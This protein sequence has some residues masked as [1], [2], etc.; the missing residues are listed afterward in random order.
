MVYFSAVGV[1]PSGGSSPYQPPEG[2]TPTPA[3]QKQLAERDRHE[4]ES[5]KL[6]KEGKLPEAVAAAEAMLAI[7]R[8][9]L[10]EAH[11]HYA[12]GL[13][14]LADVHA[15]LGDFPEAEK[16]Y[17]QSLAIRK[18][19][20]GE[21]D[22][23]TLDTMKALARLYETLGRLN[24]A[25]G[26]GAAERKAYQQ[27]ADLRAKLKEWKV[28]WQTPPGQRAME[29][30][31]A[32]REAAHK[33]RLAHLDADQRKRLEKV[34][35]EQVDP[36]EEY[37]QKADYARGE[38]LLRAAVKV[39]EEL[40]GKDD[41]ESIVLRNNLG[42]VCQ[43]TGDYL[44]AAQ[45]FRDNLRLKEQVGGEM[46]PMYGN[47]LHNLGDLFSDMGNLREA[48][49]LLHRALRID[50]ETI[51][52]RNPFYTQHLANLAKLYSRKKD[53]KRA[54]RFSL[55]VIGIIREVDGDKTPFDC[56]QLNNLALTYLSQGEFGRAEQLMLESQE[57]ARQAG[58][59][60]WPTPGIS[61][62]NRGMLYLARGDNAQAEQ[63]LTQALQVRR[64]HFE[65]TYRVLSERRQLALAASLRG[66][67]DSYLSLVLV[68]GLPAEPAY[69]EM[70]AWKGTAFARQRW[71]RLVRGGHDIDPQAAG[72]LKELQD[73]A[74][75]LASV[76]FAAPRPDQQQ[77]RLEQIRKLT[78]RKEEL[79]SALSRLGSEFRGQQ[80]LLRPAPVEIQAA[81]PA[82]VALI[83][84]LEYVRHTPPPAGKGETTRERHLLAF[85]V[86]PGRPITL[87]DLGAV[88]PMAAAVGQW[89]AALTGEAAAPGPEQPDPGAE[90]R[91]LFW[92][93]LEPLLDGARA[94]LISPD[95]PL[96]HFPLAAL[97]GSRPDTYLIE[98]LPVA[99][100]PVSALLPQL[101]AGGKARTKDPQRSSLLLVGDVDF[102]PEAE[103]TPPIPAAPDALAARSKRSFH[104]TR[105][106]GTAGEVESVIRSFRQA[107]PGS[108]AGELHGAAATEQAF[109]QRAAGQRYLHL[110]THGFYDPPDLRPSPVGLRAEGASPMPLGLHPGLLSGVALAGANRS[111]RPRDADRPPGDDGILTALEVAEMDMSGTELVVLSACETGLG[112]A[113]SGEGLLGLQRA[114]Q[115]A[116][117]RTVVASLWQVDDEA[118]QQLM[119][120]FYDNLWR[121]QLPPLQ[122]LRQAQ[123]S[124]LNDPTAA[125]LARGPGTIKPAPAAGP[126][127]RTNPRLWAPWVVSGDPGDLTQLAS[128]PADGAASGK[129][130]GGPGP[131]GAWTLWLMVGLPVGLVV[132]VGLAARHLRRRGV[133]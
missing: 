63:F 124:L 5:R 66:A 130:G 28:D 13:T 24:K 107:H 128:A 95:G 35:Q 80:A 34:K 87:A 51:G 55:V 46:Y 14:H 121:K 41:P 91:R 73:N 67:L 100:V 6:R 65:R 118:T 86:R 42:V 88:Q 70:L 21:R 123:L 32:S 112:Q 56:V 10:G 102:G 110:A 50:R 40:L 104:F 119:S 62:H 111:F 29:A 85:V 43:D 52:E 98:E 19:A 2:G 76:V 69:E 96:A 53:Y 12:A 127:A 114:F 133:A 115:I 49:P 68:A 38:P 125:A 61:V 94:I 89:R 81:L 79:E 129:E 97:P 8:K 57:K 84:L 72:L 31:G 33:E 116:G 47:D 106:P 15:G 101:L 45:L 60:D 20:L 132:L 92:Q 23:A 22:P 117:A 9:V 54:E 126:K 93:P 59:S 78:E 120:R 83:D 30:V 122:A 131:A 74:A 3:Q 113:K 77:A 26:D 48:E 71:L 90:L 75:R 16:L 37:I 82:G 58:R 18:T 105:L 108:P 39:Y 99:V 1:P 7:D 103:P 27:A 44:Q 17:L 64:Q 25:R 11:P 36:A 109:R 4:Q